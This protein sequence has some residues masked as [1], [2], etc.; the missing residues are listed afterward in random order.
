VVLCYPRALVIDEHGDVIGPYDDNLDLRGI[1]T[2]AR[3]NRYHLHYRHGAACNPIYGLIRL[4]VLRRTQVMGTYT[5][6]DIV[7][8]GELALHGEFYEVPERLFLRRDHPQTTLRTYG[9]AG[10]GIAWHRPTKAAARWHDIAA[11]P[12]LRLLYEHMAALQRA[13]IPWRTRLICY[14]LMIRWAAWQARDH[15]AHTARW[16]PSRAKLG[17]GHSKT[18]HA[19]RKA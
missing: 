12:V 9:S 8:L 1:S 11:H 14:L 19:A 10:A 7:L 13:D 3:Y 18:P 16:A 6:S 15:L 4:D 5:S 17:V 2:A